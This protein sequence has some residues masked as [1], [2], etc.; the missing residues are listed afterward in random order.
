MLVSSFNFIFNT[1]TLSQRFQARVCVFSK[2]FCKLANA[3]NKAIAE[4]GEMQS[5]DYTSVEEPKIF[6]C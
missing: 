1:E 2:E 3:A 5:L 6:I 4:A